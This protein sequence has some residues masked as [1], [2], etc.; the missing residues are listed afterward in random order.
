V[1]LVPFETLPSLG[2]ASRAMLRLAV[3]EATQRLA[4]KEKV[5][6]KRI[7]QVRARPCARTHACM[8]GATLSHAWRAGRL[9]PSSKPGGRV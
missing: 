2:A 7:E 8:Q 6:V 3:V 1:R 9:A 4:R 5:T